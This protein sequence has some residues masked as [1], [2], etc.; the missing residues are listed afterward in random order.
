MKKSIV[1]KSLVFGIIMLFIGTSVISSNA[2]LREDKNVHLLVN[3]GDGVILS[4]WWDYDWN[5]RRNIAINHNY[6]ETSPSLHYHSK[7]N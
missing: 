5:C 4:I 7:H 3:Q 1:R 6:I 2:S